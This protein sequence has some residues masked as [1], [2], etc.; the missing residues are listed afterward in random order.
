M[1]PEQIKKL[2]ETEGLRGFGL[3]KLS[4]SESRAGDAGATIAGITAPFGS[5]AGFELGDPTF[6]REVQQKLASLAQLRSAGIT[7]D[8]PNLAKR[9]NGRRANQFPIQ[10]LIVQ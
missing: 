10:I 6:Q 3:E 5:S 2:Y 9:L 8:F 1:T 7:L 4:E